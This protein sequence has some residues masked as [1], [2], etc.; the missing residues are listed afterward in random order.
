MNTESLINNSTFHCCTRKLKISFLLCYAMKSIQVLRLMSSVF[1]KQGRVVIT[2]NYWHPE[3]KSLL[4]HCW[5]PF[6]DYFLCFLITVLPFS[7]VPHKFL[8]NWQ[9]IDKN[10]SSTTTTHA[11][12]HTDVPAYPWSFFHSA[13]LSSHSR[14]ASDTSYSHLAYSDPY[15]GWCLNI[16]SALHATINLQGHQPVSGSGHCHWNWTWLMSGSWFALGLA[17]EPWIFP[18]TLA[19]CW[20]WSP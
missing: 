12:L 2:G 14:A 20:L 4:L 18:V 7:L 11:T 10:D 9:R 15:P 19:L 1:L 17:S 8:L 13:A 6:R 5:H 16:V 3:E